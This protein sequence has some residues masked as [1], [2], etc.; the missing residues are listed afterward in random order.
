MLRHVHTARSLPF[1]VRD[2]P[3]Y[4]ESKLGK[5]TTFNHQGAITYPRDVCTKPWRMPRCPNLLIQNFLLLLLRA[6][7]LG[8][9]TAIAH[10]RHDVHL[11]LSVG[12]NVRAELFRKVPLAIDKS[13]RRYLIDRTGPITKHDGV[14]VSEEIQ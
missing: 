7:G 5:S 14:G 1:Y 4:P 9:H 8:S 11:K 12:T 13:L 2:L 3:V 10:C 6:K